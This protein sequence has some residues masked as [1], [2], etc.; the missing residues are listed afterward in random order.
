[1]VDEIVA[2]SLLVEGGAVHEVTLTR[3]YEA[4]RASEGENR[5]ETTSTVLSHSCLLWLPIMHSVATLAVTKLAK[6]DI[7][8]GQ[9]RYQ[10]W[11]NY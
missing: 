11:P 7:K 4:S 9:N 5:H 10:K 3:L 1:M 2:V 8:N 6:I